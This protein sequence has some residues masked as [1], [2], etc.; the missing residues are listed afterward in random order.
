MQIIIKRIQDGK[1]TSKDLFKAIDDEGDKSGS[2][3]KSEFDSL[4]KRIGMN[5]TNHRINEIFSSIK[6]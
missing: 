3:S 2:I 4:S 5:F 6:E 1:A